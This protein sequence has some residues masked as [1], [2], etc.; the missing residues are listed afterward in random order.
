VLPPTWR[1]SV[2]IL[3]SDVWDKDR[4]KRDDTR[5]ISRMNTVDLD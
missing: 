2:D 5:T 4:E 1:T 3:S